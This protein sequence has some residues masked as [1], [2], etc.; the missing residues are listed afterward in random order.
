MTKHISYPYDQYLEEMNIISFDEF[1]EMT[2]EK[3]E[4]NKIERDVDFESDFRIVFRH[5]KQEEVKEWCKSHSDKI[6][7]INDFTGVEFG[8]GLSIQD[9]SIFIVTP[10][11][12]ADEYPDL[13]P[14]Y[15]TYQFSKMDILEQL[16]WMYQHCEFIPYCINEDI[17]YDQYSDDDNWEE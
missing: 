3:V 15:K 10:P 7:P 9:N 4:R 8:I 6:L 12:I 5:P 17:D 16:E 1:K 11:M 14:D 13:Y 2:Y